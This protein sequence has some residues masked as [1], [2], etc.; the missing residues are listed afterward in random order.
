MSLWPRGGV[1]TQRSA[2]PFTPVQF[3]A[4]PPAFAAPQLRPGKPLIRGCRAV[5]LAKA[6]VTG[7]I[8]ASCFQSRRG[9]VIGNRA[10]AEWPSSFPGSSAVEQPAVNR[11]V[12]GSN[13]ARGA[14]PSQ[15]Q[16]IGLG[17][18]ERRGPVCWANINRNPQPVGSCPDLRPPRHY[19]LPTPHRPPPRPQHPPATPHRPAACGCRGLTVRAPELRS[20]C[21]YERERLSRRSRMSAIHTCRR[22]RRR[23]GRGAMIVAPRSC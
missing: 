21:G 7:F 15:I 11:L 23:S 8:G 19:H 10:Y 16:G 18:H 5:A 12:A 9:F 20:V 1:V 3:R 2:K 22:Y 13:P 4:W 17:A 6:G 14:T